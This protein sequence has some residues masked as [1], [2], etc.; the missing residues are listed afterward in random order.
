MTP[1]ERQKSID[2]VRMLSSL[3]HTNIVAYKDSFQ[4]RNSLHIVME[5]IDGGDLEK[6]ISQRGI[7]HLPEKEILFTFVQVL[8]ALMYLHERH[9]LHRDIKPQNIFLSGHGIAKLGDFG[10]AKSLASTVD[11]ARTVIGTPY[12]LAPE[13]WNSAPYNTPADIWSL[14]AVL[15][16]MCTLRRPYEGASSH[17]LFMAVMTRCRQAVPDFYSDNL[18]QLVDG[19]LAQD[20]AAR[21]TAEQ[22][23]RLPFVSDATQGLIEL[24]RSILR[25][26]PLRQPIGRGRMLGV[27]Q[28]PPPPPALETIADD[29]PK[30]EIEFED[31]FIDDTEDEADPFLLLDDVT[32]M[33]QKSISKIRDVTS[34]KFVPEQPRTEDAKP[35][36]FLNA[37]A[38]D[39]YA[40][41]VE[42]LRVELE[43][44]LG[45]QELARLYQNLEDEDDPE[46]AKFIRAYEQK[47]RKAVRDVRNL[48][49]LEQSFS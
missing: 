33:L 36:P 32:T 37:S 19:M 49:Y 40:Y 41:K 3:N 10:V 24:N 31:D 18:R 4:D 23:R 44:E 48:I 26:K 13:V 38:N 17:D 14:G 39:T 28:A 21:P 7:S 30:E 29:P 15:Y 45:D 20:P 9:I 46:C 34:W 16:H 6:K 1:K 8:L 11:L 42:S 2:E 22:I 43:R 12:Y 27:L 35:P 47:N 25:T 5:Y